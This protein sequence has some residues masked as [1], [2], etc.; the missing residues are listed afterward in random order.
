MWTGSMSDSLPSPEWLVYIIRCGDGTLY[1][2]ITKDVEKRL[3]EHRSGRGSKYLRG[4]GP[5][6]VVFTAQCGTRELAL[7]LEYRIKQLP[8]REKINLIDGS[9]PL[10]G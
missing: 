6:E 5:L 2:G 1:T 10:P 3:E 7:Q 8:R 4:R 9:A